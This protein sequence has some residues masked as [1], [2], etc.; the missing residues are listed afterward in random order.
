MIVRGLSFVQ[1]QGSYMHRR[2]VERAVQIV[3]EAA[4]ALPPDF[5]AK[6][7]S[8]PWNAIIGIGNILRHEYQR[9][10]DKQLWEIATVHLPKLQPIVAQML[11]EI[12]A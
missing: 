4:K 12:G 7:P 6:H 8:A 5:L 1:Y 2:A 11:T 3:S 9:L 10:D